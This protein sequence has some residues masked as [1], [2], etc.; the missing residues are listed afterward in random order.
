[1]IVPVPVPVPV[2]VHECACASKDLVCLVF[3]GKHLG[4]HMLA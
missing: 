2:P 1:M 4:F 3:L